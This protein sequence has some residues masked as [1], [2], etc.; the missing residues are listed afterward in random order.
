MP[1]QLEKRKPLAYQMKKYKK[2]LA[3]L[4]L[5]KKEFVPEIIDAVEEA[6]DCK[7]RIMRQN[8]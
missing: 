3:S 4:N 5:K 2:M 1:S 6:L 7:Y 8:K